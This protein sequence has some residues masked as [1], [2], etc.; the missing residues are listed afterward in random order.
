MKRFK[1]FLIQFDELNEEKDAC[2]RKIMKSYGKWSARAAQATAK[3]RK[4]QGKVRKTKAGAN[5]KRWTAEKWK[6]TKTGKPCGAGGKNEYCRP[7]R[8]QRLLQK[9]HRKN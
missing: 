7:S 1:E 4:S 9:C 5:L 3:C 6:D 2:Y 8:Q